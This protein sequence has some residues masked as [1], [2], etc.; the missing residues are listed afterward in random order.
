MNSQSLVES[1]QHGVSEAKTK[2]EMVAAHGKDVVETGASTL[3]A[4]KDVVMAGGRE[5][6]GV[7]GRTRDELVRTLKDG[8]AKVGDKL[9]RIATPTRKES[10]VAKKIE[11][12]AK[13]QRKR[14]DSMSGEAGAAAA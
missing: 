14:A 8:F 13:K 9:S 2:V 11:V 7:A 5:A 4:A 3:R 1:V 12:R 6:V 10:A